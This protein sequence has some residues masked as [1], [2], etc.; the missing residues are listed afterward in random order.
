MARHKWNPKKITGSFKGLAGSRNFAVDLGQGYMDGTFLTAE[1]NED[2]VTAHTGA[3]GTTTFVLNPNETALVVVTFVQGS[4]VHAFL[5]QLVPSA[6]RNFMPVGTL[7][8]DD[9][10]GQTK[11]KSAN[12][13]IQKTAPV[14]FGKDVSGWAWSFLLAEAEINPGGAVDF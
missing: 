12:A 13:V 14:S 7:N 10:N 4:D 2:R 1:Y 11:I 3:D 6:K 8:F 5:S 9:L